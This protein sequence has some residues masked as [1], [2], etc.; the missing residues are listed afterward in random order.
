MD[1]ELVYKA[2]YKFSCLLFYFLH[3][4]KTYVVVRIL[5]SLGTI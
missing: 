2:L 3:D 4:L 1:K 5:G